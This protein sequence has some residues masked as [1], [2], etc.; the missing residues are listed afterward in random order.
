MAAF[1]VQG[2][3]FRRD[4]DA[5]FVADPADLLRAYRSELPYPGPEVVPLRLLVDGAPADVHA[6]SEMLGLPLTA[7]VGA[8][9]LTYRDDC[10]QQ[11]GPVD[12]KRSFRIAS[13]V[14]VDDLT[15]SCGER[16][17]LTRVAGLAADEAPVMARELGQRLIQR[18]G[19][20]RRGAP[21]HR[22]A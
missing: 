18:L 15:Q 3:C 22:G 2:D 5:G 14:A 17:R 8:A 16:L 7:L 20:R 9:A 13:G 4:D 21:G 1:E 19:R 10:K 11:A 12:R 6:C